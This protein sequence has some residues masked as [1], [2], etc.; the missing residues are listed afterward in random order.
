MN[1]LRELINKYDFDNELN[2]ANLEDNE[3]ELALGDLHSNIFI[4]IFIDSKRNISKIDFIYRQYEFNSYEEINIRYS[5]NAFENLYYILSKIYKEYNLYLKYTANYYDYPMSFLCCDPDNGI[6]ITIDIKP[7]ISTLNNMQ[8]LDFI[9]FLSNFYDEIPM[10]SEEV[11]CDMWK[12][13]IAKLEKKKLFFL[14]KIK[15]S[16]FHKKAK[17]I[18]YFFEIIRKLRN[19]S[20]P[21][22]NSNIFFEKVLSQINTNSKVGLV[23][24]KKTKKLGYSVKPYVDTLKNLNILQIV[25]D[26]YILDKTAKWF[27]ELE[28]FIKNRAYIPTLLSL[29]TKIEELNFLEKYYFLKKILMIDFQYI[30]E[31]FEIIYIVKKITL[32]ELSSLFQEQ[33]KEEYSNLGY[34]KAMISLRVHWLQTLGLLEYKRKI[35]FTSKGIEFFNEIT[36]VRTLYLEIDKSINAFLLLH[37][38]NSFSKLINIKANQNKDLDILIKKYLPIVF[39]LHIN[40]FNKRAIFSS[41]LNSIIILALIERGNIVEYE[42]IKDIIT[43]SNIL[44]KIGY[45]FVYSNKE[46]DGYIK[47]I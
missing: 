30:Y 24:F 11:N 17:N 34:V 7:I 29:D 13:D 23:E 5:G 8:I 21:I 40:K 2:Y 10:Y 16:I 35:V 20:V 46:Q 45:T 26:R 1:L 22:Y 6:E 42:D 33:Y 9:D 18:E 31:I 38:S 25:N 37:F 47:R 43:N 36:K 32:N 27:L 4:N 39:K 41:V 15:H 19:S 14:K 28:D 12:E 44:E 3:I